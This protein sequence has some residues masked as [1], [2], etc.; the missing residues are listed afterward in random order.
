ME[1]QQRAV[2]NLQAAMSDKDD[3]MYAKRSVLAGIPFIAAIVPSDNCQKF[4][5]CS[6]C[7]F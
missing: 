6:G 7:H 1:M 3:T 5:L 2:A 4:I